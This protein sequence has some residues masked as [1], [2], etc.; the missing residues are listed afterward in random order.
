MATPVRTPGK[1]VNYVL[2]PVTTV[3]LLG[4]IVRHPAKSTR[5]HIQ[6]IKA[7]GSDKDQV[8]NEWKRVNDGLGVNDVRR[9][10][11]GV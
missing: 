4:A 9:S 10:C 2:F 11:G 5:A 8:L 1:F 7:D 6:T 3:F